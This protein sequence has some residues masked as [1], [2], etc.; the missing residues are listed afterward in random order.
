MTDEQLIG[1]AH[2]EEEALA[3]FITWVQQG[4]MPSLI[5]DYVEHEAELQQAKDRLDIIAMEITQRMNADGA[6]VVDDPTYD[7]EIKRTH[8]YDEAKLY[9]LMEY[10]PHGELIKAGALIPEHEETVLEKW[11]ATK[12]KPFGKRGKDVRDTIDA[13]R[14]VKSTR[15][16]IKPK[17]ESR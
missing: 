12:V 8:G 7:V 9:T 15:L 6:T 14:Y 5:R 10:I 2:T 16:S 4:V 13:A 3:A 17:K 1:T 11:N